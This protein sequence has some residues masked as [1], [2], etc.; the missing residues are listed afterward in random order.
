M[1]Q[2]AWLRHRGCCD[3]SR[4]CPASGAV[5]ACDRSALITLPASD[6]FS[7]CVSGILF[8]PILSTAR[9]PVD[10]PSYFHLAS[11]TK[12][13]LPLVLE[14]DI[15]WGQRSRFYWRNFCNTGV[16]FVRCSRAEWRDMGRFFFLTLKAKLF[17]LW[18][19]FFHANQLQIEWKV[20]KGVVYLIP[21]QQF[22]V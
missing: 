20:W 9:A 22:L 4:C 19:S 13:H 16:V 11:T 7:S 3:S 2:G 10:V 5:G 6:I 12:L 1:A 15:L 21:C 18:H 8:S 14:P 17:L